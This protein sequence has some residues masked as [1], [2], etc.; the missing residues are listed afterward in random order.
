MKAP[1]FYDDAGDLLIFNSVSYAESYVE[2][3]DVKSERDKIYDSEGRKLNAIVK[4]KKKPMFFG[5]FHIE[6]EYVEFKDAE[7]VPTHATALENRL[8]IF[9][10]AIGRHELLELPLSE[11][12]R[13]SLNYALDKPKTMTHEKNDP[14]AN[15]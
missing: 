3:I 13:E 8:I 2:A 9:F 7:A 14:R 15:Q 5:L 10:N 12:I 6:Y 11:L 1:I 4:T